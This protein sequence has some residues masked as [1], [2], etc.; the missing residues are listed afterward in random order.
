MYVSEMEANIMEGGDSI[1]ELV[2]P[3]KDKKIKED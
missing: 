1:L 2:E 3:T